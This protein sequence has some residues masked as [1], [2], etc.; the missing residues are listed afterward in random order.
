MRGRGTRLSKLVEV[1]IRTCQ[2]ATHL[3]FCLNDG[4]SYTTANQPLERGREMGER[5]KEERMGGKE[6]GW[7]EIRRGK[8]GGE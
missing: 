6:G 7:E 5:R 4:P 2:P 1:A 3:T 8:E